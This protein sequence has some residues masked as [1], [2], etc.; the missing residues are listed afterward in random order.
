MICFICKKKGHTSINCK[1]CPNGKHANQSAINEAM[2][3][4]PDCNYQA[5]TRNTR[6]RNNTRTRTTRGAAA[7]DGGGGGGGA[8]RFTYQ[9]N[10]H[11]CKNLCQMDADHPFHAVAGQCQSFC[12]YHFLEAEGT[13]NE[14]IAKAKACQNSSGRCKGKGSAWY[15]QGGVITGKVG[16][17]QLPELYPG[18]TFANQQRF[19][20]PRFPDRVTCVVEILSETPLVSTPDLCAQVVSTPVLTAPPRRRRHVVA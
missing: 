9:N 2:K 4:N 6:T 16:T 20:N 5:P 10:P 1:L 11:C 7:D 14:R 15:W 3:R 18:N 17:Q 8:P 19:R 13:W 12:W